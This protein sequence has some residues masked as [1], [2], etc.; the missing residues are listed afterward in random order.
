MLDLFGQWYITVSK[1]GRTF[2]HTKTREQIVAAYKKY[3]IK[4]KVKASTDS[5]TT[6]SS[7]SPKIDVTVDSD[8]EDGQLRTAFTI[9]KMIKDQCVKYVKKKSPDTHDTYAELRDRTY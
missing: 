1:G 7:S 6:S 5:V 4:K 9:K 8:D 2:T 3:Q